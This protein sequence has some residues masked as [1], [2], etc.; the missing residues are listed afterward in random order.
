VGDPVNLSDPTGEIADIWREHP[1]G[2]TV[3]MKVMTSVAAAKRSGATGWE[4]SYAKHSHQVA[5]RVLTAPGSVRPSYRMSDTGW[6]KP[7]GYDSWQT[8]WPRA[9][10]QWDKVDDFERDGVFD[11]V[12]TSATVGGIAVGVVALV[13]SGVVTGGVSWVVAGLAAA[14]YVG[15]AITDG[16]RWDKGYCTPGQVGIDVAQALTC[17]VPG[18]KESLAGVGASWASLH[19]SRSA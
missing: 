14:P 6:V 3:G 15:L 10:G 9:R 7:A 4:A 5:A 11:V 19:I 16:F 17:L 8:E 1:G 12:R 18:G 13:A 2:V